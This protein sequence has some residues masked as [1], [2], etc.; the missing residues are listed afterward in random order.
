MG[1]SQ[2]LLLSCYSEFSAS[3]RSTPWNQASIIFD[4]LGNDT[5]KF[6]L[7]EIQ[8]SSCNY[9]NNDQKGYFSCILALCCKLYSELSEPSV[10]T[11]VS[12]HIADVKSY[13]NDVLLKVSKKRRPEFPS[14]LL[15]P[16]MTM[17]FG[18]PFLGN[19]DEH[20]IGSGLKTYLLTSAICCKL[21]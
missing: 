18:S 16:K 11:K 13:I 15:G 9:K 17:L 7:H 3:S 14:Y 6:E 4:C 12:Q 21:L 10:V 8:R 20:I 1:I 19:L 5:P 2:N